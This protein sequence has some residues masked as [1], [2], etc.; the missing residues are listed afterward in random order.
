M[1]GVVGWCRCSKV[2]LPSFVLCLSHGP[3][4]LLGAH[5]ISGFVYWIVEARIGMF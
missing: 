3:Y 2:L 5:H 4:L 1:A